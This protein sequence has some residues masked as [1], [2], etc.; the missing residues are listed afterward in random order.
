MKTFFDTDLFS[1]SWMAARGLISLIFLGGMAQVAAAQGGAQTQSQPAP[2]GVIALAAQDV[3]FVLTVPGRA[4]AYR[5]SD[6]RPQVTGVID[7]ISYSPGEEVSAG[8]LMFRI[9]SETFAADKRAAEAAVAR[10]EAALATA[11]NTLQRYEQ[12]SGRSVSQT[13]VDDAEVAVLSAEADL[14]QARASLEL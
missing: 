13:Q 5:E 12:L 9:E 2:V 6:I 4:V 8:E 11:R 1:R 14:E 3:P 7:E 10:A